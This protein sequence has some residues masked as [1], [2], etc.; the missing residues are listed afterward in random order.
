MFDSETQDQA[1]NA[2]TAHVLR[3]LGVDEL[4]YVK[5][6]TSDQLMASFPAL[7]QLEKGLTLWAL[8]SA[9]GEPLA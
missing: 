7:P 3:Q 5:E 2:V 1:E 4:A 8:F 9:E 6:T